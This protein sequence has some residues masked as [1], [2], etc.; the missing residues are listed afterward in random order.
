MNGFREECPST[1]QGLGGVVPSKEICEKRA[2]LN[3]RSRARR[4]RPRTWE[5]RFG[6]SSD[7]APW[8]IPYGRRRRGVLA[9]HA[10]DAS[11]PG[12]RESRRIPI[13]QASSLRLH[14]AR[15]DKSLLN[16][17]RVLPILPSVGWSYLWRARAL[18]ER[19]LRRPRKAGVTLT[20]V[21]IRSHSSP[22]APAGCSRGASRGTASS[23]FVSEVEGQ[24]REA[25]ALRLVQLVDVHQVSRDSNE[26]ALT[27][28]GKTGT[29]H[30][31]SAVD[32]GT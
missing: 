27:C 10:P 6:R 3:W 29:A 14:K 30:D 23:L 15:E 11:S 7:I 16:M 17:T 20:F 4:A 21:R 8:P 25:V 5:S 2:L 31:H 13:A 18:L 28:I 12:H 9:S 19:I 24:T 32:R 22:D 26:N 1:P